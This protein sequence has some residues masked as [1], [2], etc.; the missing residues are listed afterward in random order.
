M[1]KVGACFLNN[2]VF[3]QAVH[4]CHKLHRR[5]S[6]LRPSFV[7]ALCGPS[8]FVMN[9]PDVSSETSTFIFN[10]GPSILEAEGKTYLRNVGKHPATQPPQYRNPRGIYI[11]SPVLRVR[12]SRGIYGCSNCTITWV[13][14][15]TGTAG[16][17]V[18]TLSGGTLASTDATYDRLDTIFVLHTGTWLSQASA[19]RTAHLQSQRTLRASCSTYWQVLELSQQGAE[20]EV[21]MISN[22]DGSSASVA[23]K[24]LR[25]LCRY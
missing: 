20:R 11:N 5:D 25:P 7:M 10:E 14:T 22:N 1:I 2:Q 13:Q 15:R 23:A 6:V 18:D 9:V 19:F 24:F 3:V 16:N 8:A 12:V 17:A 4:A 21:A